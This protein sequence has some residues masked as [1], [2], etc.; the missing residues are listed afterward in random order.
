MVRPVPMADSRSPPSTIHAARGSL[1]TSPICLVY[2]C[3]ARGATGSAALA[4]PPFE[5]LA[6]LLE[7]APGIGAVDQPVVVGQRDVHDR[8]D[9]DRVVAVL[10]LDDPWAFHERVRA[11]DRGLRLADDR[12]AV[13]GA[14]AAGV[15][16]RE[17]PA[18]DVVG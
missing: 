18:L 11:E 8:L 15:R 10:V 13:E 2:N 9:R 17:R 7:E 14:V 3:A 4:L 1:G 12:R 6:Q 16:D 5:P